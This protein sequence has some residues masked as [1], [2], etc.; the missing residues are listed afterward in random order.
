[1]KIDLTFVGM[2]VGIGRK[3]CLNGKAKRRGKVA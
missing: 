3:T 2:G 1:M